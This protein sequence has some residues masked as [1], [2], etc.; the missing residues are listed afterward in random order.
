M[1]IITG[2]IADAGI[3]PLG[4]NE[5]ARAIFRLEAPAVDVQG[6]A[7]AT[8]DVVVPCDAAGVF[9][10][11]IPE[12]VTHPRPTPVWVG[13]SW[14]QSESDVAAGRKPRIDWLPTPI[15]V[16]RAGGPLAVIIGRQIGNDLVYAAP[17][18][19]DPLEQT[20]FQLNTVTGEL[21]QWRN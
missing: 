1:P 19:V 10:A 20:G 15:F 4:P 5:Q 3:T 6:G 14:R 16:P 21:Y 11:T 18:A 13:F 9:S 7:H 8:Q 2:S 12:Y 17:N